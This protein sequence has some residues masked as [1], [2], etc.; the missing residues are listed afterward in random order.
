M[1]TDEKEFRRDL[2][3]RDLKKDAALLLVSFLSVAAVWALALLVPQFLRR[4]FTAVAVIVSV[5]LVAI[6]LISISWFIRVFTWDVAEG[7]VEEVVLSG[8]DPSPFVFGKVRYKDK[9]SR[10]HVLEVVLSS[11]GDY[12]EGCEEELE[13]MLAECKG[14]YGGITLHVLYSPKDADKGIT[15]LAVQKAKK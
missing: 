11:Y 12:E 2:L 5:P 9:S 6:I 13:R 4:Q 8:D 1:T 14:K 10:E 3:K 15:L 7:T